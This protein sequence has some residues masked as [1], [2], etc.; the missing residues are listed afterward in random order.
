M[1]KRR[2]QGED[3]CHD[4]TVMVSRSG[5]VAI[6]TGMGKGMAG[7]IAL[8]LGDQKAAAACGTECGQVPRLG[9]P[10]CG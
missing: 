10:M 4:L 9:K 6:P 1:R 5:R 7:R 2:R 3:P 8:A